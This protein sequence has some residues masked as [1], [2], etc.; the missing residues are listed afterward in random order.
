MGFN[1]NVPLPAGDHSSGSSRSMKGLGDVDYMYLWDRRVV[2][3][4]LQ[5]FKPDLILIPAGFDASKGDDHLITGRYHLSPA[6]YAEMTAALLRA[7]HH[8]KCVMSLEGG[9]SPRGLADSAEACVR[10]L[11]SY[12]KDGRARLVD[13]LSGSGGEDWWAGNYLGL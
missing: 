8:G 13:A 2:L 11:L 7:V 5:E 3:P 4:L 12:K 10:T 1:V 9:Y 6:A